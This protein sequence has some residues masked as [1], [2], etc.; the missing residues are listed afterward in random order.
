MAKVLVPVPVTVNTAALIVPAASTSAPD[1]TDLPP[2]GVKTRVPPT[3]SVT[4]V[5]KF[6]SVPVLVIPIA[7]KIVPE[8]VAVAVCAKET[9]E[10]PRT[11][12]KRASN[13]FMS[14]LCFNF[15]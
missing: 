2:A 6:I 12:T 5:P 8:A 4:K 9:A 11:T 15:N 1:P 14:L 13:F 3:A 7:D 10:N